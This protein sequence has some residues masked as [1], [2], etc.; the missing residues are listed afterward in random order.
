[1]REPTVLELH[2]RF[3]LGRG[4]RFEEDHVG[5]LLQKGVDPTGSLLLGPALHDD[6]RTVGG[7][8]RRSLHPHALQ[9]LLQRAGVLC[10]QGLRSGRTRKFSV[11]GPE[12]PF[13]FGDAALRLA[14]VHRRGLH[15]LRVERNLLAGLGHD[16]EPHHGIGAADLRNRIALRPLGQLLVE[17]VALG[18][19]IAQ[20]NAPGGEFPRRLHVERPPGTQLLGRFF[21]PPDLGVERRG[22]AVHGGV[23]R[24]GLLA[25]S[26]R[27]GGSVAALPG[28]EVLQELRGLRKALDVQQQ[29]AVLLGGFP[30]RGGDVHQPEAAQLL[31]EILTL[32]RKEHKVVF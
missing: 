3:V 23:M 20:D 25:R 15:L 8:L 12:F 13:G 11:E 18:E 5:V 24:I 10:E 27:R 31:D 29:L 2:G 28:A 7:L 26:E 4:V 14:N 1:M 6:Q 32:R 9:T 17:G 19:E 30:T 16:D 21:Q 22:L